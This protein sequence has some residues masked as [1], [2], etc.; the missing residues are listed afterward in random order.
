[1]IDHKPIS[2]VFLLAVN[3]SKPIRLEDRISEP[4]YHSISVELMGKDLIKK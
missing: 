1:M 2:M 4:E 3:N